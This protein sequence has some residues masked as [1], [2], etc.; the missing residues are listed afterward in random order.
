[1][2]SQHAAE[3]RQ[4]CS[5]CFERHRELSTFVEEIVSICT[6]ALPSRWVFVIKHHPDGMIDKFKV[7]FVIQGFRQK[8]GVDFN[9]IFSPTVRMDQ[10]RLCVMYGA[11]LLGDLRALR[12]DH[13][14]LQFVQ[15]GKADVDDAYLTADLQP[16][17]QLLFSLPDGV[18]LSLVAPPGHKV[19]A[20]A[21][22]AQMGLRQSGR[23]WHQH[24]HKVMIQKGFTTCPNAPCLY[25]K[26]TD[27]DFI[28]VGVFVDDLFL[29]HAGD[30]RDA[31]NH[32]MQDLS[33]SYSL[34]FDDNL[35]KF[36]CAEFEHQADGIRMHLNS[37]I[38]KALDRFGFADCA[39]I[40]TPEA[41]EDSKASHDQDLLLRADKQTFQAITGVIMWAM[42]TCRP[43]LAH[44]ANMLARCMSE[45][46]ACDLQASHRVLRYLRGTAHTGI[47]FPF[48]SHP[49]HPHLSA[50][51]D[52]DWAQDLLHRHSTMGFVK[53]YNAAPISWCCSSQPIVAL[54]SCEAEY[55]AFCECVREI[56]YLR[57]ISTF[58]DDPSP[59]PTVVHEDNQGTIDL[60]HNQI[61]HNSIKHIDVRYHYIRETLRHDQVR[62]IKVPTGLNRAD[63]FTKPVTAELFHRHVSVLGL[64]Q[65]YPS[66]RVNIPSAEYP[67]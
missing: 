49:T 52:S 26:V 48:D 47:F 33:Q 3:W 23:A 22:K 51:A 11:K 28:I 63:L 57:S 35:G 37:Y 43:D 21:I 14:P 46:R 27:N 15:M 54:S 61:H 64:G 6:R 67:F 62:V 36:L 17:E 13:Y 19:V 7:R 42:T 29:L 5:T 2:R 45:P 10:I 34:K 66:E 31:L 53:L 50:Y 55:I 32:L 41:I 58:L 18:E 20:R 16:D 8:K 24:Q 60:V 1:M 39:P 59:S 9:E 56:T 25:R 44:A 38:N 30:D 4:A 40:Q 12:S 65:I